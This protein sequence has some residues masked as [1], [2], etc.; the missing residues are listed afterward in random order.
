MGEGDEPAIKPVTGEF[1]DDDD[2]DDS[3]PYGHKLKTSVPGALSSGAR[4]SKV[5]TV[6]NSAQG[7]LSPRDWNTF[8]IDHV[9]GRLLSDQY[10]VRVRA[11]KLLHLRWFHASPGNMKKLLEKAGIPASVRNLV[12]KM[13]LN[14][15]FAANGFHLGTTHLRLPL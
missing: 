9:M 11:L 12:D 15:K 2:L 6:D 14:A 5:I 3:N 4:A 1:H 7:E 10:P 8:D 13:V